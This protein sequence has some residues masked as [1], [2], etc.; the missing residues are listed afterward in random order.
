MKTRSSDPSTRV[1]LVSLAAAL[2]LLALSCATEPRKPAAP[3]ADCFREISTRLSSD[4]MEGRGIGTA[5]LTRA[6]Q[7]LA[8]RF[9]DMGLDAMRIDSPAPTYRQSFSATIGVRAGEGNR[10]SWH[11]GANPGE[12]NDRAGDEG[13]AKAVVFRDE[14]MPFGFSSS[15]SFSGE[16][17]FVGYGI[18]AEFAGKPDS[19]EDAT[20]FRYDDYDG[21]DLE[22]R[23][24]LAMRYEPREND[25]DSPFDGKRP[26]R[27]SDLRYKALKAREAGATALVFVSPPGDDEDRLP[28][29]GRK[30]AVSNAG[31]PV[32]QVSREVADQWFEAAGENLEALHGE[33]EASLAPRSRVLEGVSLEGASDID[34]TRTTLENIVAAFPGRGALADETVV[35]GAHFDHLGFGGQGSLDPDSNEVHNG[36]D[37]NASGVA[38]MLC[39]VEELQHRLH[40][41][42]RSRRTLVVAAFD[43]EETRLLGSNYFVRHPPRPL[44]DT[45]A[46][47][48]LDMVGRLRN[49]RLHAFGTDSSPDWSDMLDS[50]AQARGFNLVAGGDGYGP[51]DQ[52]SFYG[53]GVPVV[54]FFT[55]SHSEYHTPL[56]DSDQLNFLGGTRVARVV[57]DTLTRLLLR[58]ERLAYQ[59]SGHDSTMAG[60]SRGF[61]AYLGTVPDYA[62]MMSREGGVLLS[63]VRPGAPADVAGVRGGDRII[64]IDGTTIHNLHDMTF[65]LR[66]HRPGEIVEVVVSRGDEIVRLRATLGRRGKQPK[67]NPN[68]PHGVAQDEADPHTAPAGEPAPDPAPEEA[69]DPHAE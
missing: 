44:E 33:I 31:I 36:A 2:A 65:V 68:D 62:D 14:F 37:D 46:M 30:G 22:G 27:F 5:G 11:N 26:S 64:E 24:A 67:V 23:I 45:V 59:S 35:V 49:H 6:T 60:D 42:E 38:A 54:H 52:M 66:D 53:A 12:E 55:G 51:S 39:A 8:D 17:V 3:T 40:D 29:T 18:V 1:R 7:Y 4:D 57:A 28:R 56:D 61:G 9:I 41:D 43:G 50:I 47:V 15:A 13:E 32:I 34:A 19:G 21:V 10:L 63:A 20:P 48:N 58:D 25:P 16:V 69:H